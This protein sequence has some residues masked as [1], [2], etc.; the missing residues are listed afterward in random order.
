[1]NKELYEKFV[2]KCLDGKAPSVKQAAQEIGVSIPDIKRFMKSFIKE[3]EVFDEGY[4][5]KYKKGYLEVFEMIQKRC[6]S[7]AAYLLMDGKITEKQALKYLSEN[8]HEP[9]YLEIFK[10]G[11]AHRKKMEEFGKKFAEERLLAKEKNE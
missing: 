2:N 3:D 4:G 1:M 9:S 7:N 10:R 6:S 5:I 8:C 11:A